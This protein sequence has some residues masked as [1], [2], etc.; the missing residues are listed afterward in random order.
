MRWLQAT[1]TLIFVKEA[2][3]QRLAHIVDPVLLVVRDQ[4]ETGKA[5]APECLVSILGIGVTCSSELPR[6]RMNMEESAAQLVATR[7]NFS[8]LKFREPRDKP[9]HVLFKCNQGK[10]YD[11]DQFSKF[12][13]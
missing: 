10:S 6:E 13:A 12:L 2:I 11:F 4:A 8:K 7:N 3:P 5:N 9:H 1:S